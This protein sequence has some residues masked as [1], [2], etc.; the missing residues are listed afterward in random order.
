MSNPYKDLRWLLSGGVKD[1][2]RQ[3]NELKAQLA[4]T[5]AEL[6]KSQERVRLL[7]GNLSEHPLPFMMLVALPK[8]ASA[9]LVEV[10]RRG[11]NIAYKEVACGYFP[12]DVMDYRKLN[13]FSAGNTLAKAHLDA[14][15]I[16]MQLLKLHCPRMVLHLRDPRQALLSMV[17]HLKHCWDTG[18]LQYIQ[19]WIAPAPPPAVLQGGLSGAIDWHLAHFLPNMLEW[20][21]RWLAHAES[22]ESP[23]VLI[24]HYHDLRENT[25]AVIERIL[26]FYEIPAWAFTPTDVPKDWSVHFRKGE[27]EE[28][29]EV[30]NRAQQEICSDLMADYPRVNRLYG[31]EKINQRTVTDNSENAIS[32]QLVNGSHQRR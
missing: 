29:R 21:E 26:A 6:K 7:G 2:I 27:L 9:Y 23:R 25:Q 28:W 11:L 17:H 10:L 13:Q 12:Q 19:S 22:G 20:T 3:R 18:E 32:H 31:S 14:N 1:T 4:A 8:S 15:P 30:F 16:N 5:Q 24:T